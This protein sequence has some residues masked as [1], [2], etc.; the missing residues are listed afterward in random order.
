VTIIDALNNAIE[1]LESLDSA[2]VRRPLASVSVWRD[3][4]LA[5]TH[6]ER[7]Y[8]QIAKENLEL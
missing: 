5:L 4:L 3:L 7:K 6:L 1:L 2:L 8:P